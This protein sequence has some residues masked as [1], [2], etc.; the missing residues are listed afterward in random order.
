MTI[1]IRK[2]TLGGQRTRNGAFTVCRLSPEKEHDFRGLHFT[3]EDVNEKEGKRDGYEVVIDDPSMLQTLGKWFE[4]H[5]SYVSENKA[6]IEKQKAEA[7][8]AERDKAV[9]AA[10]KK[11]MAKLIASNPEVQKVIE[12]A[13]KAAAQRFET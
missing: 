3:L 12:A 5:K 2:R 8:E 10:E 13:K 7:L 4:N 1:Y 11:A 9:E 6:A